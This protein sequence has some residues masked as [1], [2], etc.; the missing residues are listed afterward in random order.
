MRLSYRTALAC[1]CTWL[2][3][4]FSQPVNAQL[5]EAAMYTAYI[6]TAEIAT[7]NAQWDKVVADRQE[8]FKNNNSNTNRWNLVLAQYGLMGSTM[9]NRDEKRFDK[10]YEAA[11]VHLQALAKD[12]VMKAEAK[13]LLSALYGLKMG[14]A[15]MAGMA[16]GPKSSGLIEDALK[17][18][19]QSPLAWRIEASSKMYTPSMFG[20]DMDEAIE[21]FVKC[22]GLFEKQP[23]TLKNNWMYLDAHVFLGQAYT[24]EGQTANAIAIYEKALKLEPNLGWVKYDLLPKAKQKA[25]GK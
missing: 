13:A 24:S 19:P 16:L 21:A 12:D 4:A 9:R 1:A 15:P 10:Y 22:I 2:C 8:T 17:L 7:T 14:Y 11:E 23:E 20:G 6:G 25:L 5:Q 18:A 3:L